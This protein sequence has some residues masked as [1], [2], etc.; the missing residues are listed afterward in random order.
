MQKNLGGI[1]LECGMPF[2]QTEKLEQVELLG[3][4]N[5]PSGGQRSGVQYSALTPNIIT[6]PS[7]KYFNIFTNFKN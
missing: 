1:H 6:K 2:M 4:R 5:T 3:N 7:T